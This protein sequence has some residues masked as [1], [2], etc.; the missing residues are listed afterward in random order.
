MFLP[1]YSTLPYN[2]SSPFAKRMSHSKRRVRTDDNPAYG[3]SLRDDTQAVTT[4]EE[5]ALYD[6][7]H[8]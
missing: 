4:A 5:E 1:T 7:I 2:R 8:N 6:Q 3:V